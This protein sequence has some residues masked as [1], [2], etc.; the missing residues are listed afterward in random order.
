MIQQS[1]LSLSLKLRLNQVIGR[2]WISSG[3]P[4]ISSVR[5]LFMLT[6]K[7]HQIPDMFLSLVPFTV[8]IME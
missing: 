2:S 4:I 1:N 6:G 5:K 8:N 7:E 3:Y